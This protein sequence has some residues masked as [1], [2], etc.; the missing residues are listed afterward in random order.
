MLL[1]DELDYNEFQKNS[2]QEGQISIEK[3]K[4]KTR[5]FLGQRQSG[6]RSE[7]GEEGKKAG[8]KGRRREGGRKRREHFL[9]GL[10]V[11][12]LRICWKRRSMLEAY[13]LLEYSATEKQ[14]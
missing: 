11:L 10:Q 2:Q 14:Q 1:G 5:R 3:H 9:L 4:A 13:I 6:S 7:G 12:R 8:G